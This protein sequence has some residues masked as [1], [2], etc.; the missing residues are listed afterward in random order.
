LGNAP[1]IAP[2][3]DDLM[4]HGPTIELLRRA[5]LPLTADEQKIAFSELFKKILQMDYSA[6]PHIT[7]S[8]SD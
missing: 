7:P 5:Q 6:A 1:V 8:G 3:T 2:L 4:G